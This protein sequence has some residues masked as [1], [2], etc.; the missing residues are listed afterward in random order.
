MERSTAGSEG[1]VRVTTGYRHHPQLIRFRLHPQPLQAMG[2]FLA[3]LAGEA[4]QRGYHFNK[5]RILQLETVNQIEEPMGNYASSGF[6]CK[7]NC[8]SAHQ[9]SIVGFTTS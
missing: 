1:A 8:E 7:K 5:T 3:G 6:T 4:E 2:V 9:L